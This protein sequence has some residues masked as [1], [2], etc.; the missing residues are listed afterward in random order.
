[1]DAKRILSR[2]KSGPTKKNFTFSLSPELVEQLQKACKKEGQSMSA[3]IEELIKE[4]LA[5]L[6]K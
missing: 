2:L 1:M 4:F 3:V 5:S 6:K